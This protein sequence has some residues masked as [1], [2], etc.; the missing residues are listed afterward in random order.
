MKMT[1]RWARFRSNDGRVGFGILDADR[2]VEYE[3]DLFDSPRPT[4]TTIDA[5]S[6]NSP[7]MT[8][9][10]LMGDPPEGHH[11]AKQRKSGYS[12]QSVLFSEQGS[13]WI[14]SHSFSRIGA[15]SMT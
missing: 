12:L 4:G 3:G 2:I 10:F 1:T 9:I 7:N 8:A 5:A 14:H 13:R 6:S 15:S 11:E